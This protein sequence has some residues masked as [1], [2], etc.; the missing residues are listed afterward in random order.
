DLVRPRAAGLRVAIV[1][2]AA[3]LRVA[4]ETPDDVRDRA[5]EVARALQLEPQTR[6]EPSGATSSG[7]ASSDTAW[8]LERVGR[9]LLA[10]LLAAFTLVARRRF[11]EDCV[12]RVL[13][14]ARDAHL[15][16]AAWAALVGDDGPP[17]A[18]VRL[19]RRAI[20]LAHPDDLLRSG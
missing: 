15:M 1:P 12:E 18:Y 14:L 16:H 9:E 19:S 11:A 13:F 7:A 20:A 4:R 3:P 5:T 2:R 6:A 10:P 17:A 8:A